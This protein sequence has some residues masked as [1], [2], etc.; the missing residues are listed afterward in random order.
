[1]TQEI[2]IEFKTLLSKND[3]LKLKEQLPFPE[4]PIKQTNYYFDTKEMALKQLP[5]ALRIREKDYHYKLTLKQPLEEGILETHDTLSKA[6][7]NQWISGHPII[8]EN[9]GAIFSKAEINVADLI[10]YGTL[11][12]DRYLFNKDGMEIVLDHSHYLGCEDFELEL[13]A[14]SYDKGEKAFLQILEA[15]QI[16]QQ[17][18][19]SKIARFFQQLNK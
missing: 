17:E 19:I 3:F 16:H 9:T 4:Q 14:P 7:K 8:K 13:E 1:M 11:S 12:T 6:E 5:A 2:E 10:C 18:P 15:Y